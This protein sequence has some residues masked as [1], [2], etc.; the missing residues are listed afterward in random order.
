MI[1]RDVQV[2]TYLPG[3]VDGTQA[4]AKA[5]GEMSRTPLICDVVQERGLSSDLYEGPIR[6]KRALSEGGNSGPLL[7]T[8]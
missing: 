1:L 7:Q 3:V 5:A 2:P 4:S 8:R 6:R